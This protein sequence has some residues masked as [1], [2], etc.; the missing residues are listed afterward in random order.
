LKIPSEITPLEQG[1]LGNYGMPNSRPGD[2]L[3]ITVSKNH[4]IKGPPFKDVLESIVA[5]A[6][7]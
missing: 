5:I 6:V 2:L 7:D 4:P 1:T 3:Q